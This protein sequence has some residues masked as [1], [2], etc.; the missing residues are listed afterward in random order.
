MVY[1]DVTRN[2]NISLAAKGLYAYLS[3]FCG[4]SDECYP[5]V[6]TILKE[7]G[8]ARDTFYR[9]I[10]ALV[11]A[12]VVEKRQIRN[13]NNGKFERTIYKV[14][15]D[16]VIT[17]FP[18]TKNRDAVLPT[19]GNKYTNNNSIN[20]NSINNNSINTNIGHSNNLPFLE[21]KETDKTKQEANEL[22]EKVWKLY[23][24]KK[25]KGQVSDTQKKKL[26]KVGLEE[27]TRAIDRYKEGLSRDEWR[28][29]QNGSTFFNSGYVD[30]LDA[31]WQSE[32]DNND[33]AAAWERAREEQHKIAEICKGVEL[34]PELF[35][36]G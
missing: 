29:P 10:N 18:F 16:V 8:I 5:S 28:K 1:Q 6:D 12:G 20:N 15:H 22:F 2:N 4:S 24:N 25:G 27:L 19:T 26:F 17:D 34:D 9:H 14:T 7:T 35:P 11:A 21:N 23:P 36:N 33:D 30:Y 13:S 3:S 31:N 32:A